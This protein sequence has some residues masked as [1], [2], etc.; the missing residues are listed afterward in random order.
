MSAKFI[1]PVRVYYEDTDAGGVVYHA[2]YLRF[3]ERARSE[4][5]RHLGH[6][7]DQI[8]EQEKRVFVVRSVEMKFV[9]PARLGE[10]L[11]VSAQILETKR[12]SMR[13]VQE[14]HCA[15]EDGIEGEPEL[16][17]SAVV[18]LAMVSSETFRPVAIPKFLRQSQ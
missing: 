3:M 10:L 9:R 11:Q 5:L 6:P 16:K 8:V 1:W 12:A 14:V 2:N 17:V 13:L 7:V 18:E 4:W 15:E